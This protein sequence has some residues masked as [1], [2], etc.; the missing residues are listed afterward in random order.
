MT[1]H[2]RFRRAHSLEILAA[3]YKLQAVFPTACVQSVLR[4]RSPFRCQLH[5]VS[6]DDDHR[7]SVRL[8]SPAVR[9]AIKPTGGEPC[10]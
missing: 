7:R 4:K 1:N 10:R 3:R 6:A 5:Q 2:R 8:Q 9:N